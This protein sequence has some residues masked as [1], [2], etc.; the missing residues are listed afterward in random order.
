MRRSVVIAALALAATACGADRPV[1]TTPPVDSLVGCIG[2]IAVNPA[3][4]TLH[5]GDTLRLKIT[6]GSNCN[7][8]SQ[9][10]WRTSDTLVATI[11]SIEGVVRAKS[12]GVT[13]AIA[14]ALL[15][16]NIK[17]AAAITVVP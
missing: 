4:A 5:A 16:R 15:D 8:I 7:S 10:R 11:D 14:E 3:T 17:G 6:G 13:T 9:W 1:G 2:L 12:R